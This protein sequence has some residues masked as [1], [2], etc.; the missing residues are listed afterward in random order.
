MIQRKQTLYLLL[1]LIATTICLCLPIGT[2]VPTGMGVDMPVYNLWVVTPSGH[3]FSVWVLFFLLLLTCPIT[4]AAIF[5][6]KNRKVQAKLCLLNILLMVLWYTFYVFYALT[7][8]DDLQATFHF[9]VIAFL[10]FV[11]LLLYILARKGILADEA[12]VR[13]MDRIR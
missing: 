5:L 6:Y 2:F 9:E 12:L 1:A 8:G 13:S 3:D 10:P 11:A 7:L 4:I